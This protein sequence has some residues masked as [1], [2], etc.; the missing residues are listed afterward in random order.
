MVR[1][2]I[3]LM[4]IVLIMLLVTKKIADEQSYD[5]IAGYMMHVPEHADLKYSDSPVITEIFSFH[6]INSLFCFLQNDDLLVNEQKKL[7]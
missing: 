3:R 6:Y 2:E 5:R 1:P 4:E 7:A